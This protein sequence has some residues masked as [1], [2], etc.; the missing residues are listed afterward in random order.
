[1]IEINCASDYLLRLTLPKNK[2]PSDIKLNCKCK[3]IDKI[4]RSKVLSRVIAIEKFWYM[5]LNHES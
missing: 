5:C 3:Y 2:K 4:G 1:L